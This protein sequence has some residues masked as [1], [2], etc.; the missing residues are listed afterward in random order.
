MRRNATVGEYRVGDIVDIAWSEDTTQIIAL[1]NQGLLISCSPRFL[2]SCE[3]EQL[4]APERWVSPTAIMLWQGKLYVLD[5][6]ANQVWRYE[7]SGGSYATA[8]NEYF[9]ENRPDI[10]AAVDFG[11]DD[12]G[13]IYIL[14]NSGE[15][16]KWR[17]GSATPFAF[18]NFPSDPPISSADGLFLNSDPTDQRL[19]IVSRASRTIYETS[20]AGTFNA[21]YRAFNEADFTLLS[22]VV[23]DA[24]QGLIYVLSGNTVFVINKQ[25]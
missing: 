19:Y 23:A 13:N 4:L 1:D 10:Q 25:K 21:S 3:A 11:I 2:Q 16:T 18:V 22:G 8:P 20:L 7:P 9:S 14:S 17:G 6:G 24:G 12:K 15:I 5:P